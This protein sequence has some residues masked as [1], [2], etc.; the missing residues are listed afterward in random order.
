MV[1]M[2]PDLQGWP[3]L[4]NWIILQH[5][6]SGIGKLSSLQISGFR[7]QAALQAEQKMAQHGM[8]QTSKSTLNYRPRHPDQA[9]EDL[10]RRT[11]VRTATAH[12]RLGRAETFV[13]RDNFCNKYP[14]RFKHVDQNQPDHKCMQQMYQ[15][16]HGLSW[17]RHDDSTNL[18]VGALQSATLQNGFRHQS[19]RNVRKAGG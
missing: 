3:Y 2:S 6:S 7:C 12:L 18:E 11:N 17:R 4:N 13:N 14:S 9:S 19:L 1:H 5:E 10:A 8:R 15:I 16:I